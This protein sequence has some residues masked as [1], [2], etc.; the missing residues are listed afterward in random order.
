[1]AASACLGDVHGPIVPRC[2]DRSELRQ[3]HGP[4][5][6]F[7]PVDHAIDI[8]FLDGRGKDMRRTVVLGE[9]FCEPC[10]PVGRPLPIAKIGNEPERVEVS[11]RKEVDTQAYLDTLLSAIPSTVPFAINPYRATQNLILPK[12]REVYVRLSSEGKGG[13]Y[14]ICPD[15]VIIS[16]R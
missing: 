11:E 7:C 9:Q 14:K 8:L 2:H 3:F 12:G 10:Q 15:G 16:V 6:E 4:V 5:H 1:M 13:T